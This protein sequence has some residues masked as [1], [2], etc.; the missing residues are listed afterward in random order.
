MLAPVTKNETREE[1]ERRALEISAYLEHRDGL[2]RA[3]IVPA[4]RPQWHLLNIA[5]GKEDIAIGHLVKRGF[6]IFLPQFMRGAVLE[7]P[8]YRNGRLCGHEKIDMSEKLIVPGRLFVFVW[9]I[10]HHWRRIKACTGVQ[11]I[12]L[13]GKGDPVVISEAEINR[14]QILQFSL[15]PTS[16][17]CRKR[18]K[19][20]E[21]NGS[22]RI[23]TRSFWLG[24]GEARTAALDRAVDAR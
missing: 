4:C 8:I 21:E 18:Y 5:P 9:D 3:E 16:K 22:I 6:G 11:R 1:I 17:R 7:L 13:T 24:T 12:M 10:L 20:G 15:F 14:L 2:Y 19:P 23:K